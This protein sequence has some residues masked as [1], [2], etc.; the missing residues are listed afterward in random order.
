[1]PSD[2]RPA[3]ST[4]VRCP[5]CGVPLRLRESRFVDATFPCP[6]C[7]EAL[8][9][10]PAEQDGFVVQLAPK[11]T[12]L[13]ASRRR[14]MT[15][16]WPALSPLFV[17]WGLAGAV[18][19][20]LIGA[21]VR[22]RLAANAP[23][24]PVANDAAAPIVKDKSERDEV[25]LQAEEVPATAVAAAAPTAE[26]SAPVEPAASDPV[27]AEP[28]L[29][30]DSPRAAAEPPVSALAAA[31][32]APAEPAR[33]DVKVLL[34][35]RLV[36]FR[37]TKPAPRRALLQ[38]IEDLLDRPVRVADDVSAEA[39]ATLDVAVTLS[40]ENT[41]VENLLRAILQDTG[42]EYVCTPEAVQLRGVKE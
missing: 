30:G 42:L 40:L 22:D 35:Q 36:S 8:V 4:A 7:R 31:P 39:A 28:P 12:T 34:T 25:P 24:R 41:T 23:H 26:V 1:M 6:E 9:L 38:T 33:P 10:A 19:V 3:A 17:A 32:A 15:F 18:A 21:M 11:P 5:A 27:L 14:A 20:V 2:P 16:R 37:Q 13:P 29:P